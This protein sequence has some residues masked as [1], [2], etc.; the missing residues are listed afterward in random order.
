MSA[1]PK[2][3]KAVVDE[4]NALLSQVQGGGPRVSTVESIMQVL[5]RA[6]LAWTAQ[7]APEF[8]GCHPSNRSGAMVSASESHK[9]GS[10]ILKSGWSW[11]KSA[12]STCMEAPPPGPRLEAMIEA[13]ERITLFS[14][15]QIPPL[16]APRFFSMGGSHT[17][18][19]LRSVKANSLAAFAGLSNSPDGKLNYDLLTLNRPEFRIACDKGMQW[20]V[21]HCD[22]DVVWPALIPLVQAGLNTTAASGQGEIEILLEISRMRDMAL[23][24]GAEPAWDSFIVSAKSSLPKCS[25]YVETLATFVKD[26]PPEILAEL[27]Q[28]T[29]MFKAAQSRALGSEFFMKMNGL[30]WG[31]RHKYP[32]ISLAAIQANLSSD[33]ISDGFAKLLLPSALQALTGK[34]IRPDVDKA[35][36]AMTEARRFA[37]ALGVAE[38]VR[39]RAIATYNIRLILFLTKK[40]KDGYEGREFASM[41]EISQAT[42]GGAR[43]HRENIGTEAAVSYPLA[44]FSSASALQRHALESIVHA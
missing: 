36:K 11:K 43:V 41:D 27:N 32:Y 14:E 38:N 17:N 7:I 4:V 30:K 31:P 42:H 18:L 15:G 12:D 13:N 26:Q 19:F 21:L 34:T 9:L 8:I 20:T 10:D 22:C 2:Y 24:S 29:K 1:D 5:K 37:E 6:G 23:K 3:T 35:E 40:Q 25:S 28:F 44:T 39:V 33:K 16:A